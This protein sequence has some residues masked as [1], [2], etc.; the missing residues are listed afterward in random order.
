MYY[1]IC[2]EDI[3]RI[4]EF[5]CDR[6]KYAETDPCMK[7]YVTYDSISKLIKHEIG[8][9]EELENILDR[10]AGARVEQRLDELKEA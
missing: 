9:K 10:V 5:I 3:S 4:S 8:A 6:I 2:D 1:Q 7:Q